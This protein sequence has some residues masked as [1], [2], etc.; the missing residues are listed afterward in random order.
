M[1]SPLVELRQQEPAPQVLALGGGDCAPASTCFLDHVAR[2][3][4]RPDTDA[5]VLVPSDN[6]AA[7]V[8]P[9]RGVRR[10]RDSRGTLRRANREGARVDTG[11]GG[12]DGIDEGE[13][14]SVAGPQPQVVSAERDD[15][16]VLLIDVYRRDGRRVATQKP[17]KHAGVEV[18]Q[19]H[20]PVHAS[21]HDEAMIARDP[22]DGDGAVMAAAKLV[23]ER[24]RD[25]KCCRLG[26]TLGQAALRPGCASLQIVLDLP[27]SEPPLRAAGD[28][29][30]RA[31]AQSDRRDG[32]RAQ[33][34][35]DAQDAIAVSTLRAVLVEIQHAADT[36]D[37]I[38]EVPVPRAA[39]KNAAA[40]NGFHAL[41]GRAHTCL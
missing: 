13:R 8:K 27:A 39:E 37:S 17:Q 29:D 21:G 34:L 3:A 31:V 36:G 35:V 18:P 10:H 23:P 32:T 9:F 6:D 20:A 28:Q 30:L 11:Q 2:V 7:V 16:P 1:I 5:T 19:Q 4:Q 24:Q 33:A 14:V 22:H 40:R 26:Q 38:P 41:E 25:R 15:V 12:H